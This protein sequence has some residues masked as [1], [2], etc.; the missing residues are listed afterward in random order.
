MRGGGGPSG[1]TLGSPAF[2]PGSH[3]GRQRGGRGARGAVIL[4]AAATGRCCGES[5]ACLP[6]DSVAASSGRSSL[7]EGAGRARAG[8]EDAE[9]EAGDAEGEGEARKAGQDGEEE[10]DDGEDDAA[11]SA[12]AQ[13]PLRVLAVSPALPHGTPP[14]LRV[15]VP[16]AFPLELPTVSLHSRGGLAEAAAQRLASAAPHAVGAA[17]RALAAATSLPAEDLPP[18]ATGAEGGVAQVLGRSPGKGPEP[19]W[20]LA[21]VAVVAAVLVA[22]WEMHRAS[23]EMAGGDVDMTDADAT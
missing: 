6:A 16:Q 23:E 7:Q 3:G 15:A 8:A 13:R 19:N 9:G 22:A 1:G 14:T 11:A 17:L 12:S 18:A 20:R 10:R 21:E 2:R 4:R 5:A